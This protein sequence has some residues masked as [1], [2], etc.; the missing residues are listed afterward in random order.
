MNEFYKSAIND[1]IEKITPKLS[2]SLYQKE[3]NKRRLESGVEENLVLNYQQ[4]IENSVLKK[5][6]IYGEYLL[7]FLLHYSVLV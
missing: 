2:K 6:I 4:I 5:T 3:T 7:L 1:L